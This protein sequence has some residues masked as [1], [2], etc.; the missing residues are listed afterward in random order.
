[1]EDSVPVEIHHRIAEFVPVQDIDSNIIDDR[2]YILGQLDELGIDV[3]AML[4]NE[5]AKRKFIPDSPDITIDVT[6][7]NSIQ[8][9]IN[10]YPWDAFKEVIDETISIH[11]RTKGIMWHNN[12]IVHIFKKGERYLDMEHLIGRIST[13]VNN[14]RYMDDF[15]IDPILDRIIA[16]VPSNV[17]ILTEDGA[18]LRAPQI[19]IVER[20]WDALGYEK[21]SD[22]VMSKRIRDELYDLIDPLPVLSRILGV[23]VSLVPERELLPIRDGN[24]KMPRP[25][26]RPFLRNDRGCVLKCHVC[27][28][29]AEEIHDDQNFCHYHS[30][31]H[32]TDDNTPSVDDLMKLYGLEFSDI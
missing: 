18:I 1:M 20:L 23:K 5:R 15:N 11:R 22:I 26:T 12:D 31:H 21:G 32:D 6:V 17:T 13:M 4:Q 2:E 19:D 14:D 29:H 30:P 7:R 28:A 25:R 8:Y 16:H 24:K 27:G 9:V 10:V 3:L